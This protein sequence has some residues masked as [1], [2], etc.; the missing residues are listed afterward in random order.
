M[1]KALFIQQSYNYFEISHT[2]IF[3]GQ[4]NFIKKLECYK[5]NND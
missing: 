4:L 2:L 5:S 3:K 1:L